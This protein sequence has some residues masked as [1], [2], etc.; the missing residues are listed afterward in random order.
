MMRKIR[1][2]CFFLNISSYQFLSVNENSWN[3]D[4]KLK[5]N[6]CQHWMEG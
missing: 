5:E 1:N 2:Q 4:L 6:W 3:I